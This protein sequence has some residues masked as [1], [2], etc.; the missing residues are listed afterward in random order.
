YVAITRAKKKLFL[1]FAIN[2]S[3]FAKRSRF[4]T[5]A[6]IYEQ[7]GSVSLANDFSIAEEN[8]LNNSDLVVGDYI[9]HNFF[10]HGEIIDMVGSIITVKFA[11]QKTI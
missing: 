5:E 9:M 10:G 6:G 2:R 11:N 7:N 1:S 8:H 3:G 4:I